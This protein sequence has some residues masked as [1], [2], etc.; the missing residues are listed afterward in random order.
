MHLSS[1]AISASLLPPFQKKKK[2]K[3]KKKHGAAE[4]PACSGCS[5]EEGACHTQRNKYIFLRK[6]HQIVKQKKKK[7]PSARRVGTDP[8]PAKKVK[9]RASSEALDDD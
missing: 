7:K 5:A 3:E 8:E 4:T 6:V 9:L 1:A 2:N